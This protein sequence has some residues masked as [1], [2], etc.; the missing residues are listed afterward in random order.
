MPQSGNGIQPEVSTSGK[1]AAPEYLFMFLS[2]S[3][4]SVLPKLPPHGN[5]SET[6]EKTGRTCPDDGRLDEKVAAKTAAVQP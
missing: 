6:K 2:V 1:M 5:A 4:S 3:D